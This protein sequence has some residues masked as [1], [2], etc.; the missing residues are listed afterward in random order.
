MK[1]TNKEHST[2]TA[3]GLILAMFVILFAMIVGVPSGCVAQE[4][5]VT[6]TFKWTA[7][8]DDGDEGTASE[9]SLK[10]SVSPAVFVDLGTPWDSL[11]GVACDSPSVAG[12][13]DSAVHNFTSGVYYAGVRAADEKGNWANVSNIVS[14]TI[15]DTTPP[16]IIVNL[17]ATRE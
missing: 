1:T 14:F 3:C 7:P 15:D 6:V 16:A 13:T 12:T 10:Y 8:G 9:Y 2:W 11:P 5:P 4:N 17:T